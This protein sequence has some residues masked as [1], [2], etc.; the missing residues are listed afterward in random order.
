M[1]DYDIQIT[2]ITGVRIK[3]ESGEQALKIAEKIPTNSS[4]WTWYFSIIDDKSVSFR[5]LIMKVVEL[6]KKLNEIGYDENTELTFGFVNRENG[7]WY[8]APFD[9]INYGIDLTGE[10]YHNDEI[11]IDVDIDSVEEYQKEKADSAV[12]SFVDEIQEVLNKY[13][14]K[15][16][17]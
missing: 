15:I 13:Q 9:E 17:F 4:E 16:I 14:R 6:I 1:F 12:E 10:Q 11:N 7:N 3:A 2:L 5:R 8:E